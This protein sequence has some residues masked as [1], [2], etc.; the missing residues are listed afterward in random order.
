MLELEN[1]LNAILLSSE[2][3]IRGHHLPPSLQTAEEAIM[4]A[5][6]YSQP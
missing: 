6:I 2:G 5:A 4:M 3:V 1:V